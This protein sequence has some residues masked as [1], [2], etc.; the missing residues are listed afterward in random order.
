MKLDLNEW[1]RRDEEARGAALD[2]L[3]MAARQPRTPEQA[4][5]LD[6]R[7]AAYEV[8][9]GMTSAEMRAGLYAGTVPDTC[10]TSWWLMLLRMRD[11]RDR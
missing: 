4:A 7:I 11:R 6:A 8:R 10:Q 2:A 3:V 5:D 1:S 9:N